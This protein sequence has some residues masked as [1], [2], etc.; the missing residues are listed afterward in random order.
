M[1]KKIGIA[2]IIIVLGLFLF[3]KFYTPPLSEN[4]GK[5]EA[6]LFLGEGENQPLI[7]GF[8]GGEGGNAWASDYWKPTRDKFLEQ[9]YAFLAVGYFGMDNVPEYLDRISLN[10]IHDSIVSI[11]QHP[12]IDH[13]KVGLIGGSKGA[14]LVL[15]LASIYND[16]DAVV[17][18]VP[19]HVSFPA[20]TLTANTSSW[21]L[22]GEEITYAPAPFKVIP[23]ALKGDLH[24]AFSIMLENE[25]AVHEALIPVESING[26]VLLLSGTND[27]LWPSAYMSEQIVKRLS[28]KGFKHYYKHIAIEGGHSAPLD[29]FAEVFEFLNMHF[30]TKIV[31]SNNH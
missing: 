28:E 12:K 1:L 27:E 7:V 22:N 16:I 6:K 5:I 19:S 10:A 13:T 17:G 21:S 15:N 4:H 30:K 14:E 23:A 3:L 8:G 11:A 2:L 20:V 29:H 31:V 18:I 24:R 9:G 25:E 26:P